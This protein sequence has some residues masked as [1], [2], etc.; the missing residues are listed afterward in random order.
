MG[1]SSVFCYRYQMSSNTGIGVPPC[2]R[3]QPDD[4]RLHE[5]AAFLRAHRER[6][7][8]QELGLTV[9]AAAAGSRTPA[10]RGGAGRRHER[11]LVHLDGAGAPDQP[12]GARP[13]RTRPGPSPRS[14]GARASLRARP[15]RSPPGRDLGADPRL[16]EPLRRRLPGSPR[17]PP[18]SPMR[19]STSSPGTS[20]RRASS[21]I[22]APSSRKSAISSIF[23]SSIRIGEASSLTG[24]MS[25]G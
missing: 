17:T 2:R 11:H 25:R 14:C 8:P 20:R 19:G 5:L 22:S 23:S 6:V 21:A 12:V 1:E 9:G 15:S 10:R 4:T 24:T 3:P 7:R 18:T 16:G 13:R